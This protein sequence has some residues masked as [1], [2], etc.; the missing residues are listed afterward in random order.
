LAPAFI[1]TDV[2]YYTV[3]SVCNQYLI[4]GLSILQGRGSVATDSEMKNIAA[5]QNRQV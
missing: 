4:S 1:N 5:R 3:L 2:E